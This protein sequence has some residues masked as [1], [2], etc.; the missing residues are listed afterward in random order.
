MML[1]TSVQGGQV[2]T[3]ADARVSGAAVCGDAPSTNILQQVS[4]ASC[5]SYAFQKQHAGDDNL[6]M[7]RQCK[8]AEPAVMNCSKTQGM[9]GTKLHSTAD[10]DCCYLLWTAEIVPL[11]STWWCAAVCQGCRSALA[12]NSQQ[13]GLNNMTNM[14]SL[15]SS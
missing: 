1:I 11:C 9:P 8:P 6:T 15:V 10:A 4:T 5:C 12:G 3:V 14:L 13:T 7:C 2:L